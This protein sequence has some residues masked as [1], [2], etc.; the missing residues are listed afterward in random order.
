MLKTHLGFRK[1]HTVGLLPVVSVSLSLSLSISISIPIAAEETAT[2]AER[3]TPRAQWNR[4]WETLL[5]P[6]GVGGF[7]LIYFRLISFVSYVSA[8]SFPGKTHG[9]SFIA[10][11]Q[12]LP[13]YFA[14]VSKKSEK[15]ITEGLTWL[16]VNLRDY[17]S[18]IRHGCY[19]FIKT[20]V[21]DECFIPLCYYT[22]TLLSGLPAYQTK[23]MIHTN[24][25]SPKT[26]HWHEAENKSRI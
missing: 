12:E 21:V 4:N 18:S 7:R 20:S 3:L 9:P 8:A 16:T 22:D 26:C 10:H 14:T 25:N 1:S 11:W 2:G 23:R 17:I 15:R 13:D 19:Y 24:Q 5:A 6:L